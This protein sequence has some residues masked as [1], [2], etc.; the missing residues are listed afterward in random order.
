MPLPPV[1]NSTDRRASSS[2]DSAGAAAGIRA[3]LSLPGLQNTLRE[4]Q[5]ETKR[6]YVQLCDDADDHGDYAAE[7]DAA[8]WCFAIRAASPMC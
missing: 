4:L 6:D 3:T 2:G 5:I 7:D 8:G 1:T